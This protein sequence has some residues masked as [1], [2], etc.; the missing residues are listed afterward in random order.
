[1]RYFSL[2]FGNLKEESIEEKKSQD[3]GRMK[4]GDTKFVKKPKKG[5][6]A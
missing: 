2:V 1:M 4:R 3:K 6:W 5:Q